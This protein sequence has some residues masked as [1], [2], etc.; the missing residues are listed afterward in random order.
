MFQLMLQRMDIFR[1][2]QRLLLPSQFMLQQDA[3]KTAL[4]RLRKSSKNLLKQCSVSPLIDVF[5]LVVVVTPSI[6][7]NR[8]KSV[9]K[10]E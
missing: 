4:T 2:A 1:S 8:P 3:Y 6:L 9:L 7:L 10:E 5:K